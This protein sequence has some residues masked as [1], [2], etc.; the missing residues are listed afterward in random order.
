MFSAT[1]SGQ[2]YVQ[3]TWDSSEAV[4][5]LDCYVGTPTG[6]ELFNVF[7]SENPLPVQPR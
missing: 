7:S 1:I 5:S 3:D 2:L 6:L 4:A